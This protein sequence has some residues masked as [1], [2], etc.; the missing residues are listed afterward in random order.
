MAHHGGSSF[1][2]IFSWHQEV[3]KTSKKTAKLFTQTLRNHVKKI[4]PWIRD[5]LCSNRSIW[6]EAIL[7]IVTATN[8]HLGWSTIC[9][10]EKSPCSLGEPPKPWI[11]VLP[12]GFQ[13]GNHGILVPW[14]ILDSQGQRT[15]DF[16][17]IQCLVGGWGLPLWKMIDLVSWD[18]DIPNMMGKITK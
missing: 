14:S 18:Y 17:R 15:C 5:Q 3:Q 16:G 9:V 8:H 12:Q 7:W 6:T 4:K 2:C 11:P 13:L 1:G 10:A